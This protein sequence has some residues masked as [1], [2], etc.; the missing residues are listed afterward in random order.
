[1][2]ILQIRIKKLIVEEWLQDLNNKLGDNKFLVQLEEDHHSMA[3]SHC[4]AGYKLIRI[5]PS[6]QIHPCLMIDKPMSSL[7]NGT[8]ECYSKRAQL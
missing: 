1:M 5:D 2:D 7:N 3:N 4:G 8:I 6:G